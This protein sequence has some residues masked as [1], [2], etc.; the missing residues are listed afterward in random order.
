MTFETIRY[1]V[2]DAVA[3]VTLARPA[4]ANALNALMLEEINLAMDRAEAD[5]AVRVLS[6]P[7]RAPR[8]PRASI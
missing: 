6:S 8:S 1:E 4:R 7:A 2:T 3:T 5:E